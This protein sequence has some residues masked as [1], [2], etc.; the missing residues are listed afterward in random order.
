MKKEEKIDFQNK[1][2]Y[3]LYL[4]ILFRLIN[5]YIIY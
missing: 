2:D 3:Y 5:I 1:Y 4:V